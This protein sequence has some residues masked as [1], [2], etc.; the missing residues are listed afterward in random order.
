MRKRQEILIFRQ[1]N[2]YLQITEHKKNTLYA[3]AG[4]ILCIWNNLLNFLSAAMK[5]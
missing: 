4:M 2:A 3:W 1:K 5:V